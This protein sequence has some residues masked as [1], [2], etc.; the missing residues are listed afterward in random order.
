MHAVFSVTVSGDA[1]CRQ[2]A[3]DVARRYLELVGAPPADVLDLGRQVAATLEALSRDGER[4]EVEFHR[5]DRTVVVAIAGA[6]RRH[7]HRVVLPAS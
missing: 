2:L 5:N 4:L 7:E 1:T 6:G 3:A